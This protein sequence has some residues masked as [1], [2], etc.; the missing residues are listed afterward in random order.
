MVNIQTR[1]L[2]KRK[3]NKVIAGVCSGVADYLGVD[4]ILV[5]ILWVLALFSGTGWFAYLVAW[6]FMPSGEQQPPEQPGRSA[7]PPNKA[8]TMIVLFAIAMMS[9]G[10]FGWFAIGDHLWPA[11]FLVGG[12]FWL[13]SRNHFSTTDRAFPPPPPMTGPV[14]VPP[15]VPD[16]TPAPDH[17]AARPA[18]P[19]LAWDGNAWR[20]PPPPPPGGADTDA[21][22]DDEPEREP[23]D[24]LLAEAERIRS[25][26]YAEAEAAA[27][28]ATTVVETAPPP[29]PPA[30]G[31]RRGSVV[32]RVTAGLVV[33]TFGA[34]CL[35]DASDAWRADDV[36][37]VGT[38]LT[39]VG[40]GLLV[41]ALLGRRANGL[42]ILG[43]V[44]ALLLAWAHIANAPL[45]GGYGERF[46]TPISYDALIQAS[47]YQMSTG[48]MTVYLRELPELTKTTRFRSSINAGELTVLVDG[49]VPLRVDAHAGAGEI[50]V[51]LPGRR[52][53]HNE[54]L[55][56]DVTTPD[57]DG[58]ELVLDLDVGLGAI[59][60]APG[61]A[62][63]N[64]QTTTTGL[65]PGPLHNGAEVITPRSL[66]E[67]PTQRTMIGS[68]SL[69]AELN[70][71]AGSE[72]FAFAAT[73]R[74]GNLEVWVPTD[75]RVRITAT[76]TG[77]GTMSLDDE[78]PDFRPGRPVTRTIGRGTRVIDL[79]L[80]VGYGSITVIRQAR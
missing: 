12:G 8:M 41:S 71:V 50:D 29:P 28:A 48:E 66:A 10:T 78:E 77:D 38:L 76:M 39:I 55:N 54:G 11:L 14:V 25:G 20:T 16:G 30:S 42:I 80:T 79:D 2:A 49:D 19:P 69:R 60:V 75:A 9:I 6:I 65:F 7:T 13:L 73:V 68:G 64:G 44:L 17:A 35:L 43:L 27:L 51:E 1:R 40:A 63:L 56:V 52:T 47:P 4:V 18:P 45:R 23:I 15:P 59:T 67:L 32:G 57:T 36:T 53:V 33:L 70:E 46:F 22:V 26:W 62:G 74:N 34:F 72:N 61:L 58:P 24:P 3:D 5:R 37:V 21:D 31:R